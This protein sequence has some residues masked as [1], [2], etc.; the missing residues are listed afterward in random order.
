[1]SGE[2]DNAS[3]L[4]ACTLSLPGPSYPGLRQVV[5]TSICQVQ[6]PHLAAVSPGGGAPSQYADGRPWCTASFMTSGPRRPGISTGV[7]LREG[8][9]SYSLAR[10]WCYT[11]TPQP[12]LPPPEAL[13]PAAGQRTKLLR[14]GTKT[15]KFRPT[16]HPPDAWYPHPMT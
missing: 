5:P 7:G 15:H 8:R 14:V 10:S 16:W 6:L 1:M 12:V 9:L 3:C 13:H 2:Q 4:D 11:P